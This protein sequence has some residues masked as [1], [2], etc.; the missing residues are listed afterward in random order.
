MSYYN[1]VMIQPNDM[2][3]FEKVSA[4]ID[5]HLR[6]IYDLSHGLKEI[7]AVLDAHKASQDQRILHELKMIRQDFSI[8]RE[9]MELLGLPK[10]N[11]YER[12][13]DAIKELLFNDVWPEAIQTGDIP[14]ADELELRADNILDLIVIEWLE[15][16]R[17]LDFGCGD[18]WVTTQSAKR[19]TK[20]SVGYD[21]HSTWKHEPIENLEFYND[22]S[23]V[24]ERGPYDVVLMYDVLDHMTEMNQ[25]EMLNRVRQVLSAD[26]RIYVRNHPWCSR[27]GRHYYHQINKSFAHVIFDSTEML[28]IG[29]FTSQEGV[30]PLTKPIQTYRNWFSASDLRIVDERKIITQVPD[31]FKSPDNTLIRDRLTTHWGDE[32]PF[33][34][35]EIDFVTYKLSQ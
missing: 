16:S 22:F 33:V 3:N 12:R 29:G 8:I 19:K 17:F 32:D 7:K 15:G 11:I 23:K 26:G 13:F 28:R 18:G 31:F 9:Q 5:G 34:N 6:K 35:M 25:V 2:E 14:T 21:I 10:I 4:G 1:R 30:V 24:E 27:H 20:I